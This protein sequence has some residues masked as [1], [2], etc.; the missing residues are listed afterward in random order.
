MSTD[1]VGRL[2]FVSLVRLFSKHLR[3]SSGECGCKPHR[4]LESGIH[5]PL[6]TRYC[7]YPLL[8][9]L[10]TTTMILRGYFIDNSIT[11]P[12]SMLVVVFRIRN[13]GNRPSMKVS[14]KFGSFIIVR[15]FQR[16]SLP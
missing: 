16:C 2:R 9:L 7:Q 4:R 12:E 15:Y 3:K 11:C 6:W 14:R 5:F 1:G 8:S 13:K 10:N